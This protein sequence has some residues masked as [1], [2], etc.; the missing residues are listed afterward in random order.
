MI[1][2]IWWFKLSLGHYPLP[3]PPH[4]YYRQLPPTTPPHP[5]GSP[6]AIPPRILPLN[7]HAKINPNP[8][9][10]L[11]THPLALTVRAADFFVVPVALRIIAPILV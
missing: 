8:Y 9:L 2:K 11:Q 4:V 3:L 6:R 1:L 5:G 7:Y 10:P